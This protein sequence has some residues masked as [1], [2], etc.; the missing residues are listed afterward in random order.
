[1]DKATVEEVRASYNNLTDEQRS[2][3]SASSLSR[4]ESS[5]DALTRLRVESEKERKKEESEEE[6]KKAESEEARRKAESEEER[7]GKGGV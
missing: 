3:V 1:M 7:R 5:E 4:L 2:L 6:R